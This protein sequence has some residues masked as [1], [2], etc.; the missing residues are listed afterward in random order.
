MAGFIPGRNGRDAPELD[1]AEHKSWQNYLATTLRMNTVL[2][3]QLL[4]SHQL[5]LADVQ[6][7]DLLDRAVSGGIQMGAL[8]HAL[9]SLPSRLTRQIRRL[10]LQELVLRTANPHDRRCVVVTITAMGRVLLEQ[11]MMTYSNAVRT[12]FLGQ[13]TRPQ[14]AAM[15]TA[16]GQIG[17]ALKRTGRSGAVGG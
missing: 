1:L 15:A 10:E 2:N 5:S 14:I 9:T 16:C 17:D 11:A 4:D 7:L 6:L 8:A 12:Q 3:R 13:L